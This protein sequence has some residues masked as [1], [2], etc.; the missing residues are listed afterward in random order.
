MNDT[1]NERAAPNAP[2]VGVAFL[3]SKVGAHA[4]LG[5]AKRLRV[6]GLEPHHA[7]ILRILG[8]NSGIAQQRLSAMLGMFPS[9][10]VVLLDD[11]EHRKLIDRRSHP[12]DRRRHRLYLTKAGRRALN[13][14]GA[15]TVQLEH[16]LLAALQ[17][18]EK[19]SLLDVLTRI[20]S[21]QRVTPSV[22]P[23]YRQIGK[24]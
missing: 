21:Q 22:H 20:V 12:T 17:E 1:R 15:L 24:R 9:R 3:L 2:P 23:A 18:K 19:Q 5:F 4:A 6:L 8:S 16:H 10:L 11:L 14:I 13:K 7:G